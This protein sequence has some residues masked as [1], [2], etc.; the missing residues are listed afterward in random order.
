MVHSLGSGVGQSQGRKLANEEGFES[1]S[2]YTNIQDRE[3]YRVG[4]DTL[5]TEQRVSSLV[6]SDSL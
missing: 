1:Y 6:A 3:N 2:I 4:I 5:E